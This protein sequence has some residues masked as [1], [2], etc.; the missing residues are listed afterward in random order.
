[1]TRNRTPGEVP[2]AVNVEYYAQRAGAGLVICESTAISP[3]GVAF[4]DSPSIY[5]PRH[6]AGWRQVT[7]AVHARG[8]CAFLQ[9]FHG[10]RISHPDIRPGGGQPV[11]ASA[12]PIEEML[13]TPTGAQPIPLARELDGSELPGIVGEFIGAAQNAI[14]A[15][16]DGVEVHA[17][18]GYFLDQFLRDCTNRR[19][20]R[21]GGSPE[22]RCRLLFEVVGAVVEAVGAHRVGVRLSPTNPHRKMSDSDPETLFGLA[23]DGLDRFGM[24][25]LHMV[26][27]A[28]G[29]APES[30]Q[31]DYRRLRRRYHGAYIV[32][33]GFDLERANRWI[34]EG[35]AD[36]VAFGRP[37]IAN[38]D[39][40]SRLMAGAPLNQVNPDTLRAKGT[41]GYVD[42]PALDS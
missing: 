14:A 32:N 6:V 8:S 3:S 29:P 41:V 11:A 35:H 26:E 16:F 5:D 23:V 18:N 21:Y 39:L 27:G 20:D 34:A 42:Y 7:D 2:S 28:T 30:G 4:L 17:A 31:V 40:V 13:H 9:L 38:P 19:T 12:V 24:A 1:M 15:G 22:N 25:Y 10:G 33:N 36:L 37:F